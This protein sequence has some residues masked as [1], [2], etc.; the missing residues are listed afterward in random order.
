MAKN[1]EF[2]NTALASDPYTIKLVEKIHL[3]AAHGYEIIEL[4]MVK[5]AIYYAKEYH[6]DQKRLSGEPFY[7][8]PIEVAYMVI[9]YYYNTETIITAILHDIIEDT[10]CTLEIIQNLFGPLIATK[11]E[12]LTRVKLDC[13]ISVAEI[14]NQSY[15]AGKKDVLLIKLFDRLHNIQTI[16][17]K[18]YEKQKKII[19]ETLEL[20]ITL[21]IYLEIP[22]IENQLRRICLDTSLNNKNLENEWQDLSFELQLL[23]KSS[24]KYDLKN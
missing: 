22:V 6:G 5:K 15:L 14:V 23:F 24:I 1:Q 21:A 8:H 9:D 10:E 7:S 3:L 2:F 13:K 18:A 4:D 12:A 20:F 16:E 11:V 17:F 19:L